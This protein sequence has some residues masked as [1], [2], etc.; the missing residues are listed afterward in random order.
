GLLAPACPVRA[1]AW[2]W[3]PVSERWHTRR[4]RRSA[5]GGPG[6]TRFGMR[7]CGIS[8]AGASWR[9]PGSCRRLPKQITKEHAAPGELL[10]D[11]I[12]IGDALGAI[13][14]AGHREAVRPEQR[15][16]P[17]QLQLLLVLKV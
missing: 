16:C 11:A 5:A 2:P 3:W 10:R 9:W 4:C 14:Q 7:C 13:E 12:G 15:A 1:T 8:W 17:H 6:Q